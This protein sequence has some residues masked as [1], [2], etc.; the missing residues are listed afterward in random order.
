MS[1]INVR[2]YRQS[3]ETGNIGYKKNE[4][5]QSKNTTQYVLDTIMSKQKQITQIRNE[6]S[7]RQLEVKTNI[8]FMEVIW[9]H[10]S[11]SLETGKLYDVIVAIPLKIA[12]WYDVVLATSLNTG[13]KMKSF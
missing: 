6:P 8:A 7:Y 13:A 10:L 2:E 1:Y 12:K 4:E 5:K 9:C 11:K 3:R